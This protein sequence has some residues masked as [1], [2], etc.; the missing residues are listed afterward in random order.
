MT[1]CEA[2]VHSF[3]M[4]FITQLSCCFACLVHLDVFNQPGPE[5]E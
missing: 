1:R 2:V 5:I 4:F 3:G